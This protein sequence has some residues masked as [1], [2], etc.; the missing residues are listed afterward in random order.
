MVGRR[1]VLDSTP[2]YDAVATMDTVTLIRSAIRQVLAVAA[3]D[4]LGDRVRNALVRDDDYVEA[5]KPG[6]D[7]WDDRGCR[8][9]LVEGL[10]RDGYAVIDVLEGLVLGPVLTQAVRLLARI[11]GQDIEMGDDGRYRIARK[12]AKDRIIST[13]DPQARHGH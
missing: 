2:I 5:G 7:D 6:C 13:V 11:I 10:A 3:E 8:E 9:A 12:V 4:G 1:R